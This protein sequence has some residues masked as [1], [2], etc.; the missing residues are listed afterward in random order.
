M[1]IKE[2]SI[3]VPMCKEKR[4]K[5]GNISDFHHREGGRNDSNTYSSIT[6][7][8]P[9]PLTTLVKEE[10]TAIRETMKSHT[11]VAQSK[12]KTLYTNIP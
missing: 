9:Y 12:W 6:V 7:W 5:N 1:D 2:K 3:W 4:E 11:L 8:Y 10:H